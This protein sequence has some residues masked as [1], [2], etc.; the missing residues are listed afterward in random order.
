[1]FIDAFTGE[2]TGPVTRAKTDRSGIVRLDHP[3]LDMLS[4][5]SWRFLLQLAARRWNVDGEQL[6]GPG[7]DQLLCAARHHAMWLLRTHTR[8]SLPRI[9]ALFGG[10]DHT[11]VLSG[12]ASHIER[13]AG[14][15]PSPFVWTHQAVRRY[16]RM[17]VDGKTVE[18][19][20]KALGLGLT[21]RW[22]CPRRRELMRQAMGLSRQRLV[23]AALRRKGEARP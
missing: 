8:M 7:R 12:I 20:D 11:T 2:E 22:R 9:G 4:G 5:C 17:L 15:R 14:T 10:R 23:L 3:P 19:A 1:M 6:P 16:S 18:A 13:A 21:D